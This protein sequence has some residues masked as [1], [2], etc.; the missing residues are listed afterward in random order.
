MNVRTRMPAVRSASTTKET[1]N[2]SATKAMRWTLPLRPAKLLVSHLSHVQT[3]YTLSQID[4]QSRALVY[5]EEITCWDPLLYKHQL[6]T[7]SSTPNYQL[8]FY[9]ILTQ[10]DS[11]KGDPCFVC[12]ACTAICAKINICHL[13]S[14][15]LTNDESVASCLFSPRSFKRKM[16]CEEGAY[17]RYRTQAGSVTLVAQ[18]ELSVQCYEWK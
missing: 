4:V 13:F 6:L 9:S 7:H 5:L 16:L 18:G 8:T 17:T 15:I 2:V 11:V 12:R 3:R 14:A 10:W 1:I